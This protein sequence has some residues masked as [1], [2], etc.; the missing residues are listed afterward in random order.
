M[1]I[2]S[3]VKI[4]GENKKHDVFLYTLSTCGWCKKTKRFLEEQRIEYKYL[5]IDTCTREERENALE[6][7]NK[8][9]LP[10]GLPIIIIDNDIVISGYNVKKM[11]EA[12]DL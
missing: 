3:V 1:Q 10:L 12:L 6:D 8:R 7:I 11:R 2:I 9:N 4:E 5:D